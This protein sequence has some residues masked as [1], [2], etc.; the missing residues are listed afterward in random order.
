MAALFQQAKAN[1]TFVRLDERTGQQRGHNQLRAE[2]RFSPASTF[3]IPNSLIG[4][5]LGP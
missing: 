5:S 2:Q 4:L 1:G 3:K